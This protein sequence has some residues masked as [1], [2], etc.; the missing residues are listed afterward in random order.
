MTSGSKARTARSIAAW[1]SSSKQRSVS[2][3]S[4]VSRSAEATAKGP[5]GTTGEGNISRLAETKRT[6]MGTTS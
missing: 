3:T 5:I 4:C 2:S 6:R 1:G